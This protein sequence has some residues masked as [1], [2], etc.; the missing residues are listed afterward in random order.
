[1]IPPLA[2]ACLALAICWWIV[3]A[4]LDDAWSSS[5]SIDARAWGARVWAPK[6]AEDRDECPETL[7]SGPDPR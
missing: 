4:E 7:R 3:W 6:V 1:V 2:L 5:R